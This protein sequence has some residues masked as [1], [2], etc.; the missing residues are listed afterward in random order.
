MNRNQNNSFLDQLIKMYA[1]ARLPAVILDSDFK[2]SWCS[3]ASLTLFPDLKTTDGVCNLLQGYDLEIIK[4]EIAEHGIFSTQDPDNLF[5][6]NAITVCALSSEMQNYYLLQP[7]FFTNYG[8]GMSPKGISRAISAFNIQYRT[9][10][11]II[12]SMLTQL[13]KNCDP[14]ASESDRA[15]ALAHLEVI[16]QNT[17]QVLRTCEWIS[18]Y[19]RLTRGLS[20]IHLSRVDIFHYL[21]ELFDAA[22]AV[23]EPSGISLSQSI[24]SG[25]LPMVCDVKKVSA[26]ISNILS[27]SCRFTRNG[28]H[29]H[30]K[31]RQHTNN[32]CI[33]IVDH[34][35][36][37]PADVLPHVLEPYYSYNHS[38]HPFAGTGLGLSIAESAATIMGGSITITSIENVGTT[39]TFTLPIIDDDNI[40]PAAHCESFD[41]TSDRFSFL[42]IALSDSIKC[43]LS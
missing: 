26:V 4:S 34:G 16:N 21:H 42:R 31:V 29:I 7:S 22:A 35:L 18:I 3:D 25:M 41:Y 36:G 19:T 2:V 20:P 6:T 40:P 28:N 33:T 12:F 15:N 37:I 13:T 43:P 27:N 9:P 10:L 38:G 39:V 24:P 11:T 23:I 17:F 5:A 30:T 14:N 8:T 32:V 1:T